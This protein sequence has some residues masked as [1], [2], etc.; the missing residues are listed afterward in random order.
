LEKGNRMAKTYGQPYGPIGPGAYSIDLGDF[1][2]IPTLVIKPG[3]VLMKKL[4][5][6]D[7]DLAESSTVLVGGAAPNWTGD[8]RLTYWGAQ[9]DF[10]VV[11]PVFEG[12]IKAAWPEWD[13]RQSGFPEHKTERVQQNVYVVLLAAGGK[14][15]IC[16]DRA[17]FSGKV[18]QPPTD[19]AGKLIDYG[20]HLNRY[21]RLADSDTTIVSLKG[22]ADASGNMLLTW[23]SAGERRL[24]V[25]RN[26][27]ILSP[28][29]RAR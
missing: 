17:P 20:F 22:E 6:Y 23:G 5:S 21:S 9:A 25:D 19:S 1:G 13:E 28:P 8:F 4:R 7:T 26:H 12:M 10:R 18:D 16:L 2:F 24:F 3:E 11:M 15:F 29:K 27:L 14:H